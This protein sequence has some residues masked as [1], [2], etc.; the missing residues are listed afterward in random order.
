MTRHQLSALM[1]SLMLWACRERVL[2]R[3]DPQLPI[4]LTESMSRSELLII[5]DTVRTVARSV[6]GSNADRWVKPWLHFETEDASKS[7]VLVIG[8]H[9]EAE[10]P[11]LDRRLVA[12]FVG[13]KVRIDY[14]AFQLAYVAPGQLRPEFIDKGHIVVD[15]IWAVMINHVTT[16]CDLDL[17]RR[18]LMARPEDLEYF[19]ATRWAEVTTSSPTFAGFVVA[20]RTELR[21]TRHASD[22]KRERSVDPDS[23]YIALDDRVRL[24]R[25]SSDDWTEIAPEQIDEVQV[26][27]LGRQYRWREWDS[28]KCL[29]RAVSP[30]LARA[31][32]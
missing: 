12:M 21:L 18:T 22:A 4:V 16:E 28:G 11:E 15:R 30:L 5:Q 13:M 25:R 32:Q 26:S 9:A 17:D 31:A 14:V 29:N 7:T 8:L 27:Q 3:T 24:R 1:I 19:V 20:R 23:V 6:A 10:S 2:E